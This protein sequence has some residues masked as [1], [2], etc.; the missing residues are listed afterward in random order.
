METK[1]TDFSPNLFYCNVCLIT[2]NRQS[3]WDRHIKTK[4]HFGNKMEP[5]GNHNF[6]TDLL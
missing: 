4:K 6:T 2:C 5:N 3:E 1:E